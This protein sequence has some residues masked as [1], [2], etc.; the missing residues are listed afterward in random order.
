MRFGRGLIAL[1]LDELVMI[2]VGVIAGGPPINIDA[3]RAELSGRLVT[4]RVTGV[5]TVKA[6][7][8]RIFHAT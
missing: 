8:G 2:Q 1:D 5:Y 3:L 6:L 4:V 7:L